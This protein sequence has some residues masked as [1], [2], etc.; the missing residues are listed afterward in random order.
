MDFYG[1]VIED[2]EE[3][4][5]TIGVGPTSF[6]TANGKIK[7]VDETDCILQYSNNGPWLVGF[8]DRITLNSF[9][10]KLFKDDIKTA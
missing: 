2:D 3:V 9:L 10:K 1:D 8:F 6:T 4:R 7:K 5:F